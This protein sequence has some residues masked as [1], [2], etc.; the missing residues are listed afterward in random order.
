MSN[1][2]RKK[3]EDGWQIKYVKPPKKQGS[4][5]KR[6]RLGRISP[7]ART[8]GGNKIWHI[9]APAQNIAGIANKGRS[10]AF[11]RY[12]EREEECLATYGDFDAEK[13]FKELD[14]KLLSKRS[15]L[16]LQRRLVVPVPVEW[17]DKE[18]EEL[19]EKFGKLSEDRFFDKSYTFKMALHKGGEDWHNP[20]VHIAFANVDG[21]LK[22]IREYTSSDFLDKFEE[23]I[24]E[25]IEKNLKI[26]CTMRPGKE[27]AAK[28]YPK[29]IAQAYKRAEAAE[30]AGD[31]GAMIRNYAERYPIFDEYVS[32]RNVK[33]TEREIE[34]TE[35][36][37]EL[38][39]KEEVRVMEKEGKPEGEEIGRSEI[40]VIKAENKEIKI[41]LEDI[42]TDE[43]MLHRIRNIRFYFPEIR[44]D[45]KRPGV[46][47]TDDTPE[48]RKQISGMLEGDLNIVVAAARKNR[49]NKDFSRN[50]DIGR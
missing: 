45:K 28:H 11:I 19:L 29:W 30:L 25:F 46:L 50:K 3:I 32:K 47:I 24:K 39:K 35:R 20:H 43:I 4:G 44:T 17:L 13:K 9:S 16:V 48:N 41:I 8:G 26:E 21:N 12:I 6:T 7:P 31:S 40:A 33:K 5:L 1:R 27:K 34:L 36:E 42:G 15:N 18:P 2:N 37:I 14:D 10:S 22:N 49:K 38:L 23:A